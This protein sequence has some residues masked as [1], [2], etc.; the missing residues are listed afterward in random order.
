MWKD[1]IKASYS[2]KHFKSL[3][4][5][6]L[7]QIKDLEIGKQYDINELMGDFP[8]YYKP[9][10]GLSTGYFTQW[11]KNAGKEWFRMKFTPI[12]RN[13]GMIEVDIKRTSNGRSSLYTR[14]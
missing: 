9:N 12:A 13:S 3:K 4:E 8:N 11:W 10:K 5:A 6:I 1:I 7:N 2:S 14:I